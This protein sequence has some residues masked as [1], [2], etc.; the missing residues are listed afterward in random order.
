MRVDSLERGL[1]LYGLPR[2]LNPD[3]SSGFSPLSP[4]REKECGRSHPSRFL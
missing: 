1:D 2:G 4:L 3:G